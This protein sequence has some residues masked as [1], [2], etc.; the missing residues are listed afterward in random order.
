MNQ[1][2][3]LKM[4]ANQKQ[5]LKQMQQVMVT[6]EMQ[7]ALRLLQMPI[8]EL[9]SI[10]QEE[11]EK[12]PLLECTEEHEFEEDAFQEITEEDLFA[13]NLDDN[14]QHYFNDSEHS[15][16]HLKSTNYNESLV[17]EKI[18]LFSHLMKQ[19][20]Q[21]FDNPTQLQA[22]EVLI[23]SLDEK[24]F[25]EN[26]LKELSLLYKIPTIILKN[27]LNIIQTFEP[28]GVGAK[29]LQESFLN[30]LKL[31]NQDNSLAY[32]IVKECFPLLIQHQFQK[33]Q[34]K[35]NITNKEIYEVID[36]FL[37]KLVMHPGAAFSTQFIPYLIPD[38]SLKFENHETIIEIN[39][40]TL[41]PIKFNSH[42]LNLLNYHSTPKEL[43]NFIEQKILSAKWL[44]KNVHQRKETLYRI[45]ESLAKRQRSFF[46]EDHGSLVPLNIKALSDELELHESTITRA[47][48][49]KYLDSPKG[50]L[51]LRSFFSAASITKNGT[52]ISNQTIHRMLLKLLSEEDKT[53]PYTDQQICQLL[54][55]KGILCA[56]RTVAKYR[57]KLEIGT[58]L[59][60]KQF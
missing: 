3:S 9:S 7:Q 34:K 13:K 33:I 12:N 44:I 4:N 46:M 17:S 31:S 36:K 41:P 56:R 51:P 23:G 49:G 60:R 16:I 25:F 14:F 58:A 38:A 52:V 11:I 19:A 47:I 26:S 35:L 1:I 53:K 21:H 20:V 15:T 22:A 55:E 29:N 32:R 24:G 54:E 59:Q 48:S 45:V 50:L 27:T 43:R 10:I 30:Q 5:S 8:L 2:L 39:E 6:P 28:K 42:Y 37:C 18:S 40:E 57:A